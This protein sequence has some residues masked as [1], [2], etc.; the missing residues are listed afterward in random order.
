H[1]QRQFTAML[2][3]R[4][5]IGPFIALALGL[6]TVRAQAQSPAAKPLNVLLIISDDLRCE[7]GCYGV[8]RAHT[9]NIDALAASGICFERAYCQFPLCNP[10]R[11]SMLTSHYPSSTGVFGNREYFGAKHPDFVTLP[12]WFKDHGY[13]T[14]RMGKIFHEGID[15]TE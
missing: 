12:R 4:S 6:L 1:L 3:K 14:L 7:L 2:C 5:A 15:D 13:D 10:S 8:A 11:S 9:P